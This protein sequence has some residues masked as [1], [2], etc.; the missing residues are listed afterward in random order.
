M[1]MTMIS[2]ISSLT[3]TI[4]FKIHMTSRGS[5]FGATAASAALASCLLFGLSACVTTT[6]S[7]MATSADRLEHNAA[8]LADDARS[9]DYPSDYVHDV[10]L[11]ADDAR[12]FRNTVEDH[13][14]TDSDVRVAFERLSRGYH[15]V[16]DEVDHSD[17]RRARDD[18]RPVTDSY[19]DI[20]REMGGYPARPE[21]RASGY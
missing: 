10:H 16:R 20:E 4:A 15:A 21:H 11:L 3:S 12:N 8:M 19:L 18:L 17:S 13:S 9:T 5:N 14:S 1:V 6:R 2:R 7:N